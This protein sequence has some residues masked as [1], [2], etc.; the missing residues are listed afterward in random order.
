M[1]NQIE[2]APQFIDLVTEFKRSLDKIESDF[3]LFDGKNI[4]H[5][6]RIKYVAKREAEIF[7]DF[8]AFFLNAWEAISSLDKKS[9]SNYQKY[10][11]SVLG[12]P[13]LKAE[14]NNYILRKPLGYPGDYVMMNYI[15]D[16]HDRYLGKAS[17]EMLVNHYTTNIPISNSNIKR[18]D[19]FKTKIRDLIEQK[20][21]LSVVSVGCGSARELT[22]LIEEGQLTKPIKFFCVDFEPRAL[23]FIKNKIEQIDHEH[24]ESLQINY[25]QYDIRKLVKEKQLLQDIGQHD[26]VY[27]SGLLDY[28][29]P[30]LAKRVVSMLM[31]LVK[32]GG[33]FIGVNAGLSNDYFRAYYEFLGEWRFFHRSENEVLSWARDA[34]AA[35][36]VDLVGFPFPMDYWFFSVKK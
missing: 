20:G 24:T 18:K 33:E 27:V 30:H 16:Y 21:R 23:K 5:E 9:Y 1:L 31:D 25:L 2:V 32:S 7:S 29:G 35:K 22:E 4:D 10:Y 8:N 11:Q 6:S 36:S 12:G 14:I 19:Y 28:L 26:F 15:Y 3:E 34:N 17:L 13:L